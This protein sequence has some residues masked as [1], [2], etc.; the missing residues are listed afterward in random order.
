MWRKDDMGE[1]TPTY[2]PRWSLRFRFHQWR[3]WNLD[4]ARIVNDGGTANRELE[5]R[6]NGESVFIGGLIIRNSDEGRLM[7]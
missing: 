6:Y 3:T 5:L 1:F 4:Y 7:M 2:P